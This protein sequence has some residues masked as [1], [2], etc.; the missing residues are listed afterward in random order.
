[1]WLSS[2]VFL[3]VTGNMQVWFPSIQISY[4]F[5]LV[6]NSYIFKNEYAFLF[7]TID[8]FSLLKLIAMK[9]SVIS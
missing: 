8:G 9:R 5:E 3:S 4:V 2:C 6:F 1:M 7:V